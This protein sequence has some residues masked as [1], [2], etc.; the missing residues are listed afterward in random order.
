MIKKETYVNI[1]NT[2]AT[3]QI[4]I[5]IRKYCILFINSWILSPLKRKRE[6]EREK[7]KLIRILTNITT[8]YI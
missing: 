3:F 1:K 4:A 2:K 8:Q 6:R 7:I 5:N